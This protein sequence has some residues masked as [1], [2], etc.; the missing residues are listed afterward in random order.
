MFKMKKKFSIYVLGLLLTGLISVSVQ[1]VDADAPYIVNYAKGWNTPLQS[2]YTYKYV[3]GGVENYSTYVD[4]AMQAWNNTGL[5]KFVKEPNENYASNN[6][7][8]SN[9]FGQTGW[10]GLNSVTTNYSNYVIRI[11]DYYLRTT[12]TIVG[13]G[14]ANSAELVAHETGHSNGLKD[15]YSKYNTSI[16]ESGYN[17]SAAPTNSDIQG[18]KVRHGIK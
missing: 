11:N 13:F 6:Y 9:N 1:A 5:I 12:S 4:Q 7:I 18:F 8:Q 14:W 3:Q 10:H 2:S 17:G 16:R 15:V